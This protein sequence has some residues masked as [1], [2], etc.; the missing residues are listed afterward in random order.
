MKKISQL[1]RVDALIRKKATGTPSELAQRMAL[2]ERSIYHLIEDIRGLG[3]SIK[4]CK[5]QQTYY[6]AEE[7]ELPY[8]TGN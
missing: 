1:E 4:Y 5:F 3:A 2:S 6:Y 8:K 7:F